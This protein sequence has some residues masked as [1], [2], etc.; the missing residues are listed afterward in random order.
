LKP[1][2][3]DPRSINTPPTRRSDHVSKEILYSA[4]NAEFHLLLRIIAGFSFSPRFAGC[5]RHSDGMMR[6]AGFPDKA[7]AILQISCRALQEIALQNLE[8][9]GP[10]CR[11]KRQAPLRVR[12]V[13]AGKQ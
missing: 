4:E 13:S 6:K 3:P 1:T 9:K 5:C 10:D 7:K 2:P 11:F 12:R 8:F